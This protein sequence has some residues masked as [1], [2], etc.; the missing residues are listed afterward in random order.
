MKAITMND[1]LMIKYM[2]KI[3]LMAKYFNLIRRARHFS[4]RASSAL[5]M[6]SPPRFFRPSDVVAHSRK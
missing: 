1:T 3:Y 2:R 6:A 5:P 4:R